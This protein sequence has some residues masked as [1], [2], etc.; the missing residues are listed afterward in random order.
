MRKKEKYLIVCITV[1]NKK[2]GNAII[3]N[4]L[5]KKLVSCI[6]IIS[7]VD[8]FYWWKSKICNTKELLLMMKTTHYNFKKLEKYIKEI[9]PYE[10]PEIIS[11][12]IANG[13]KDYLDWIKEYTT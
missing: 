1:P 6:N 4:I 10:V 12:N 7:K 9:H 13:S 8:S 3:K 2:T 5:P 11:I